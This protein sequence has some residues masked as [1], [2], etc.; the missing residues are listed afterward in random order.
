VQWVTRLFF[1]ILAYTYSYLPSLGSSERVDILLDLL[2]RIV[3]ELYS[4]LSCGFM[5]YKIK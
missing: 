4:P 3:L 2:K 1:F 5:C